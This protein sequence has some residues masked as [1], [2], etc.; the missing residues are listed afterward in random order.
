MAIKYTN[1]F[2]CKSLQ[3]LPKF[4][5]LV[6]KYALWQPRFGGSNLIQQ[7]CRGNTNTCELAPVKKMKTDKKFFQGSM[8]WFSAILDNFR[9]KNGFFLKNECYD[10]NFAQFNFVLSQKANFF[11]DFFGENILKIIAS[12]PGSV[13]K[14]NFLGTVY[15]KWCII[16]GPVSCIAHH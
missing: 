13:A 15:R 2:H 6:W 5:F 8:L 11:A 10:Q 16:C 14:K 12:V 3:N 1:T 7:W 9:Q 4:G